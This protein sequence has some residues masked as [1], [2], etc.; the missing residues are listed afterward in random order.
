[1]FLIGANDSASDRN[2]GHTPILPHH[3]QQQYTD[4]DN[5]GDPEA[6]I[7]STGNE[8][9]SP[10]T[11]KMDMDM[12]GIEVIEDAVVVDTGGNSIKDSPAQRTM[13]DVETNTSSRSRFACCLI[14]LFPIG[15]IA[16]I[17]WGSTTTSNSTSTSSAYGS[18]S[19]GGRGGT[20]CFPGDSIVEI[21]R[22][23]GIK[24]TQ[25]TFLQDLQLGDEVRSGLGFSTV[26]AF[27]TKIIGTE[28]PM[29]QLHT[30]SG[31]VLETTKNH[32][33]PTYK[34]E[35]DHGNVVLAQDVMVGDL[36]RVLKQG[37]S[38]TSNSEI[39]PS[40]I[41]QQ[42]QMTRIMAINEISKR[43]GAYHP[44]TNDGHIVVN[45]VITS[46]HAIDGVAPSAKVFGVSVVGVQAFQQLL[47]SPLRILCH[48]SSQD[49]CSE[50][51]HDLQDGSHLYLNVVEPLLR[52]LMP[53]ASW[54]NQMYDLQ[55]EANFLDFSPHFVL[56]VCLLSCLFFSFCIETVL[57][58]GTWIM[59]F[60]AVLLSV[61]VH[62]RST[63]TT[64]GQ[65]IS[66][67]SLD[68]EKAK[69]D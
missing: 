33:V 10:S 54:N 45:G 32:F 13:M 17:I 38:T 41:Q 40:R 59:M 69:E 56:R 25:F 26:Y 68:R 7:K 64:I 47:Y 62:V 43:E 27:G 36:L 46:V 39:L 30:E 31:I 4:N 28:M 65:R 6:Q 52:F 50:M 14:A 5:E 51:H 53:K 67:F 24:G 29:L 37:N 2:N 44:L 58:N 42:A 18:T 66:A 9:G 35:A 15:V 23:H 48:V 1:M 57:L 11:V 21:K 55:E 3:D 16:L 20:G 34:N 12:D 61:Q 60:V 63:G 49:Y 22:R 19:G 8:N